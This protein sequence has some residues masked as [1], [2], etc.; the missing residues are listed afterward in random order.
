MAP[1]LGLFLFAF[2]L[3]TAVCPGNTSIVVTR[4]ERKFPSTPADLP[5]RC[6][7]CPVVPP[8]RRRHSLSLPFFSLN[9]CLLPA[10]LSDRPG[11]C[12][13]HPSFSDFSVMLPTGLA[14][15]FSSPRRVSPLSVEPLPRASFSDRRVRDSLTCS[16]APAPLSSR[17][18]FL[19]CSGPLLRQAAGWTRPR[20]A[21]RLVSGSAV[22]CTPQDR[23]MLY[24]D[25]GETGLHALFRRPPPFRATH[26]S[27]PSDGPNQQLRPLFA[28]L[29]TMRPSRASTE[30]E[31]ERISYW[32][33]HSFSSLDTM[34]SMKRV[35]VASPTVLSKQPTKRENLLSGLF[36]STLPSADS[37]NTS[38][39]DEEEERDDKRH[40]HRRSA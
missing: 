7:S 40:Q 23:C 22:G 34:E 8:A 27:I 37:A 18:C 20:D 24:S 29:Y 21:T 39:A 9:P 3:W 5:S 38:Q 28:C 10:H 1:R 36:C 6:A 26:V 12:A 2:P 33:T 16:S 32:E 30:R 19:H 4:W 35:K 15:L 14:P 13:A 31:D 17:L 25:R 11:D